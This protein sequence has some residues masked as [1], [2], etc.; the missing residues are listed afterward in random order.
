MVGSGSGA[1]V[2]GGGAT[3]VVGLAA[4][5]VVTVVTVVE[6]TS[7]VAAACPTS[8]VESVAFVGAAASADSPDAVRT[9]VVAPG[10]G[11]TPAA[12]ANATK[13]VE[14]AAAPRT[15]RFRLVC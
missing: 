10:P 13:S 11:T 2:A 5:A 9:V 14:A 3:P 12:T 1:A 8:A 6:L 7:G 15:P 4:G